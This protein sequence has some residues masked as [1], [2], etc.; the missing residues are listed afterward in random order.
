MRLKFKTYFL[1]GVIML[2]FFSCR[3]N[4]ANSNRVIIIQPFNNFT[5]SLAKTVYQKLKAINPN[6]ILK[7]ALPLPANAYYP[8]RNRYRADSLIRY[9]SQF[10]NS[11]AVVIGITSK[12]ISTTNNGISDWGIMGL[13]Y[14]PGNA[15]IV[16]TFRLSKTN[17]SEQFYKVAIHELGHTQGLPHC[18]NKKC[19]MRDAEGGNTLIEEKEFCSSCKSFL[20]SRGCRFN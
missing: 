16:S 18:R 9:L 8:L 17:L 15:C 1:F 3:E 10:G 20:K 2:I 4:L 19:F 11:D 6:T 7:T 13:G 14:C 12:D 5:P